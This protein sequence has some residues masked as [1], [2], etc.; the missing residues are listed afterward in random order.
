MADQTLPWNSVTGSAGPVIQNLYGLMKK[1][2]RRGPEARQNK[3]SVRK[4]SITV[5][6][7]S[8]GK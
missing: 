8:R 2:R 7:H 3:V 5:K 1:K 4:K 6:T